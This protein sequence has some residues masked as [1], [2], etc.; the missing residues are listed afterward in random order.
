MEKIIKTKKDA[1]EYLEEIKNSDF[2]IYCHI[3]IGG[4]YWKNGYGNYENFYFQNKKWWY[5]Y[6]INNSYLLNDVEVTEEEVLKSIWKNRKYINYFFK[7][8]IKMLDN[9]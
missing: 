2:E 3:C 6:K 1:K 5:N 9:K 7:E 4:N 8:E